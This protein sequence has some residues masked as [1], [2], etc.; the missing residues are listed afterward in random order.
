MA[1]PVTCPGRAGNLPLINT[2]LEYKTFHKFHVPHIFRI[3]SNSNILRLKFSWGETD[4]K[5]ERQKKKAKKVITCHLHLIRPNLAQLPHPLQEGKA[6]WKWTEVVNQVLYIR[7]LFCKFLPFLL[8]LVDSCLPLDNTTSP[9]GFQ[10]EA[11]LLLT[12]SFPPGESPASLK[13]L[14]LAAH[15]PSQLLSP[16][17]SLSPVLSP[18]NTQ[19]DNPPVPWPLPHQPFHLLHKKNP[20]RGQNPASFQETVSASTSQY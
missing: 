8:T 18:V 15:C 16:A 6:L 11:V 17:L 19:G 20:L 3:H 14:G 1:S 9:G 7:T 4:C 5:E 2:A 10:G 12:T 13:L